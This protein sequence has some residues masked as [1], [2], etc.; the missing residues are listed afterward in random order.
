MTHEYNDVIVSSHAQVKVVRAALH[1]LEA[2]YGFVKLLQS[3]RDFFYQK[4]CIFAI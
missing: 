2:G 4:L 1:K 3:N